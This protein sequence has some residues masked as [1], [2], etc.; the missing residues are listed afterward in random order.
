MEN[1]LGVIF[2]GGKATRLGGISKMDIK[3]GNAL[4]QHSLLDYAASH[5]QGHVKDIALSVTSATTLPAKHS[6]KVIY[7][8]TEQSVA[9]ALLSALKYAKDEGYDAILTLPV[10]T[11][12]LPENFA[13]AM[14]KAARDTDCAYAQHGG[15]IQ[16]LHSLWKTHLYNDLHHQIINIKNYKISGL[17]N[18]FLSTAHIFTSVNKYVFLNI[19]TPENLEL[20]KEFTASQNRQG[21]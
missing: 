6:F 14:I 1:I 11:P 19:N 2:C 16:G 5:L 4:G 8:E 12:F 3:L 9:F 13:Q 17:Y 10:D 20:A 15:R 21:I 18:G 7:D